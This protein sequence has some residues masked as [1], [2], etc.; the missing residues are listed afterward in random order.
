MQIKPAHVKK[1]LDNSISSLEKSINKLVDN[2][3]ISS[4][5]S[6]ERQAKNKIRIQNLEEELAKQALEKAHQREENESLRVVIS[7]KNSELEKIKKSNRDA[8]QKIET[9]MAEIKALF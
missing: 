8:L 3:S 9:L 4:L 2:I 1:T 7:R 5:S 6:D